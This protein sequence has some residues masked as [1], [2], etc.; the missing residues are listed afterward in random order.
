MADLDTA[1]SKFRASLLA[2]VSRAIAAS[3]AG[4][5]QDAP[6]KTSPVDT[7][8]SRSKG[9]ALRHRSPSPSSSSTSSSPSPATIDDDDDRVGTRAGSSKLAV[10]ECPD[11]RFVCALDYRSYRLRN[12]YSTC[13]ASQARKVRRAAKNMKLSFGRTPMFNGKEP[14]KVFSWLRKFV[15]ALDDNDVS[16]GMGLDLIS[17]LL[18]GDA[19]ALFTRNLPGSNI[20]GGQ[21]A[22]GSFPAAVN[23]LL[24]TYA[25][26][27]SLE[28]TQDQFSRATLVGNEG[29]DA[30]A[31]RLRSL[32]SFE[33][34]STPRGR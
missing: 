19:D 14:L 7:R 10:F 23:L 21:R 17:N 26:P 29:V 3:P 34:T 2:D 25:E 12:R 5:A 18:A 20:G 13:G 15:N 4:F 32:P 33:A 8:K 31:A 28:L 30:F 27:H 24:W 11:D 22:L 6:R 1:L 16:E 9:K